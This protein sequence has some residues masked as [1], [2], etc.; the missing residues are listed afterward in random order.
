MFKRAALLIAL[1]ALALPALAA[2]TSYDPSTR[3]GLLGKGDV[4][5]DLTAGADAKPVRIAVIGGSLTITSVSDD[6]KIRCH[7]RANGAASTSCTGNAVLAVITGSH[8]QLQASGKLF[9]LGIPQGY[10]GSVD[11]A[12]AKQC[13]KEINC[14]RVLQALRQRARN[15]NG[16]DNGNGNAGARNAGNGNTTAGGD[17][18]ITAAPGTDES[19]AQLQAALAALK[20]GKK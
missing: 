18:T 10:S 4:S 13:G 3:L 6:V 1:A 8:F 5:A 14:Q 17:G 11:A 9:L 2:A 15:G 7:S 16:N 12:T 19:L 20:N